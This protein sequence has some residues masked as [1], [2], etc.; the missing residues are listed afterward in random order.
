M[1]SVYVGLA[2]WTVQMPS[3]TVPPRPAHAAWAAA[4]GAGT[5]PTRTPAAT[6]AATER[7]RIVG[8]SSQPAPVPI[9]AITDRVRV[10]LSGRATNE[11]RCPAC[12]PSPH[13][14]DHD[15]DLVG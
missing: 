1:S 4:V 12:R 11:C 9:P 14:G 13:P 10:A 2:V 15:R 3:V 5:T 7:M 8:T 6:T